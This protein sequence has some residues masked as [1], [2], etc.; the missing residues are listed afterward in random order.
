MADEHI[1]MEFNTDDTLAVDLGEVNTIHV[2]AN[3][4]QTD[5]RQ[6]D[7]IK[8]RDNILGKEDIK[9]IG[10]NSIATKTTVALGE[11]SV[12]IGERT[13]A[14]ANV[15]T[16]PSSEVK[17]SIS[18]NENGATIRFVNPSPIVWVCPFRIKCTGYGVNNWIHISGEYD[19]DMGI[20]I[21]QVQPPIDISEGSIDLTAIE[22]VFSYIAEMEQ[23]TD[24]Q[25]TAVG[26]KSVAA[27]DLSYAEGGDTLAAGERSHAEGSRT[28]AHGFGSHA[29]GVH[30]YT[31]DNAWFSH[32]EGGLTKAL[33][34][35]AHAEG[36][37]TIALG[38]ASHAEGAGST[39]EG[40]CAHAEGWSTTAVGKSSHSEGHLSRAGGENAHSEGYNNGATGNHSHAEGESGLAKGRSSHSEGFSCEA[41]GNWSHA[42]G[43][44]CTAN[45]ESSHVGGYSSVS[46]QFGSI[47]HGLSL[48]DSRWYQAVFGLYNEVPTDD[49]GEQ[50]IVGCGSGNTARANCFVAGNSNALGGK[51][52][53]IGKTVITE[54]QL[55]KLLAL[56]E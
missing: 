33:N 40:V 52:I 41:N 19:P 39:A 47:L 53:K 54:A 23:P 31:S 14:G 16:I 3:Y 2:Q 34:K 43:Y 29:E 18:R 13:I 49:M 1:P 11:N 17:V 44:D 55:I 36:S 5:P 30:T 24:I 56:I 15:I 25:A 9:G 48:R 38:E 8:G 28:R 32:A 22:S 37:E 50:L 26:G 27:G 45:G 51:Y 20:N 10:E 4:N 42:E 12:A 35:R 46:S 21:P 6:K 7:Y